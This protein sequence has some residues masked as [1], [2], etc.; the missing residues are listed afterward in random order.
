MCAERWAGWFRHFQK[1]TRCP[2]PPNQ[3]HINMTHSCQQH[4]IL[5]FFRGPLVLPITDG[6]TENTRVCLWPVLCP[7]SRLLREEKG[8]AGVIAV[9]P[10]AGLPAV[11]ET[12]MSARGHAWCPILATE[13]GQ[14]QSCLL[15]GCFVQGVI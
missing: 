5:P 9:G 1:Y 11:Q 2:K 3:P 14:G 8:E 10:A 6:A 13:E 7:P 4:P 12:F 15:R